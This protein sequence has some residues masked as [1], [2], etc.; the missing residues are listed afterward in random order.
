MVCRRL[1]RAPGCSGRPAGWADLQ[2]FARADWKVVV[3]GRSDIP[4]R[5]IGQRRSR[6]AGGGN[7]C[8]QG[9]MVTSARGLGCLGGANLSDPDHAPA[10]R[11]MKSGVIGER[12]GFEI[13]SAL[14]RVRPGLAE[15]KRP[16]Q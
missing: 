7:G 10:V 16:R 4:G 8:P 13:S 5:S 12:E 1:R 11:V 9:P 2:A 15:P 3:L 6:I 14:E